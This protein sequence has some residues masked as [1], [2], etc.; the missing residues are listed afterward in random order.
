MTPPDSST[1]L[2]EAA[3]ADALMELPDW[4][5]KGRQIM[6]VYEFKSY[7]E[8]IEFVNALARLAEQMNHHPDLHVTWRKVKVVLWTHKFNAVSSLDTKFAAHAERIFENGE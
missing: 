7:L 2:D 8:G 5:L 1:V 3:I 6:K 4:E